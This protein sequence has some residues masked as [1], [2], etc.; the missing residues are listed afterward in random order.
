M[1]FKYEDFI[2]EGRQYP[3]KWTKD[4][5]KEEAIKFNSRSEFHKNNRQ[6]YDF[7]SKNGWLDEFYG[8][9]RTLPLGHWTFDKCKEEALKYKSRKDFQIGS[10]SSYMKSHEKNWLDEIC[11]HMDM[12]YY[13]KGYWTINRCREEALKYKSRRDFEKGSNKAYTASNRSN[14]MDEVCSH[15]VVTGNK[16]KRCIYSV[17]FSD[18]HVYVGL[19]YNYENRFKNHIKDDIHNRSSVLRHIKNSGLMPKLKQLTDYIDVNSASKLEEVIKKEYEVNGWIILNRI[20]C[21]SIGGN[22]VSLWTKEKCQEESLKYKTK[23]EFLNNSRACCISAYKNKWM[24]EICSHMNSKK[25]N[26]KGYWTK[27]KCQEES[28][29]YKSRWEFEKGSSSAYNAARRNGWRDEICSHM[30]K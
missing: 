13:P 20:K 19:T 14:W 25:V 27:E 9:K 12:K 10:R 28:I 29:K 6:A 1:I 2:K 17:E 5:C 7:S 16:F 24:D 15:M 23:K 26:H 22:N 4:K 8:V 11:S 21:G 30:I 18:N 3:I